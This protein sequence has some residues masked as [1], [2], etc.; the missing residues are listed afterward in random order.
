MRMAVHFDANWQ[1]NGYTSRQGELTV[2]L[3]TLAVM[4]V[5]FTLAFFIVRAQKPSAAWPMVVFSYLFLG[6]F[7]YIN[8]WILE[9]NL[10]TQPAH[11]ELVGSNSPVPSNSEPRTVLQPHL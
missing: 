7:S 1:P 3:A 11:S 9:F 10:R 2:A 6:L 8:H 4:Q 5:T